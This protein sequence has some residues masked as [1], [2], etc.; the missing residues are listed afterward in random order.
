MKRLKNVEGENVKQL[1]AIEYQGEN[2]LKI[3]KDQIKN[4][5][6]A[7]MLAKL[8]DISNLKIIKLHEYG[9][10]GKGEEV[11]KIL[12]NFNNNINYQYRLYKSGDKIVYNF[13]AFKSM[14]E[15]FQGLMTGQIS[16]YSGEL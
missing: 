3:I 12:I 2:Q 13:Y 1:K 5:L 10:S 4:Q 9:I 7:V 15:L 11:A 14:F 8:A 6:K 16:T